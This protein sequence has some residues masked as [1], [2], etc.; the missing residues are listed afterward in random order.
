MELSEYIINAIQDYGLLAMA[1]IITLEYACFPLPSELVLPLS[2]AVAAQGSFSFVSVLLLSIAGGIIGSYICY[3]IGRYGGVP[4]IDKLSRR[5]PGL[6]RGID[7]A[8]VKFDKYSTFSVG[9]CRVIPLCRTY[10]SFVAGISKQSLAMFTLASSI[11]ITL[12]NTVL[13]GLGFMLSKNWMIV[14]EYYE[15]YKIGMLILIALAVAA[16][17]VVKIRINKKA[18]SQETETVTKKP[19]D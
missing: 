8:K 17:I 11:G 10:V 16:Y 6:K 9:I 1:L 12:W 5:F 14:M 7:S 13:V 18:V 19:T 15:K 3:F 2:G 4:L